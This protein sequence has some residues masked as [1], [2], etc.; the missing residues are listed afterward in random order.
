MEEVKIVLERIEELQATDEAYS[1]KIKN[2]FFCRSALDLAGFAKEW[3]QIQTELN[4][5]EKLYKR[6]LSSH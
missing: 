6:L 4:V 5:L 1:N 3:A 2:G